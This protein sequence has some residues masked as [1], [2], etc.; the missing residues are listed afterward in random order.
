MLSLQAVDLLCKMLTFNPKKR[1]TAVQALD[2]PYLADVRD[3]DNE[4]QVCVLV[5]V[6]V[7]VCVC[8]CV[9]VCV[10]RI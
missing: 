3:R 7:C 9:C 8:E 4:P 2:H 1:I 10:T 5:C 6:C